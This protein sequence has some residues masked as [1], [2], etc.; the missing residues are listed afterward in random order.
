MLLIYSINRHKQLLILKTINV[1]LSTSKF[2]LKVIM[3]IKEIVSIHKKLAQ[4]SNKTM[5]LYFIFVMCST[6][7]IAQGSIDEYDEYSI[8]YIVK[9]FK[10]SQSMIR[11]YWIGVSLNMEPS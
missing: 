8:V 2:N 7:F 3:I 5:L 9:K 4:S 11:D 1:A 10:A 6:H